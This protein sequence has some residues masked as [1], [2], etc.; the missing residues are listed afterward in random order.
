MSE[1]HAR[2]RRLR[3]PRLGETLSASHRASPRLTG[4]PGM[5]ISGI[6][7][8]ERY[9]VVSYP[10]RARDA[11]PCV[12]N[13][14]ERPGLLGRGCACW[15]LLFGNPFASQVVSRHTK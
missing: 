4:G 11:T 8:P 9:A 14:S 5:A 6:Q 1:R 2:S 3:R 15:R 13:S 10:F 7:H 12:A